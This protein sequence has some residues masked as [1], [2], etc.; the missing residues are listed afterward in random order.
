MKV[1]REIHFARC[2]GLTVQETGTRERSQLIS[3]SKR[4]IRRAQHSRTFKG[5]RG[6]IADA[7]EHLLAVVDA[8]MLH[9]GLS[10]AL[11]QPTISRVTSNVVPRGYVIVTRAAPPD[12]F[13]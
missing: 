12:R 9:G 13:T 6:Q 10:A 4:G 8:V 11:R 2:H 1:F 7:E 5:S 3:P